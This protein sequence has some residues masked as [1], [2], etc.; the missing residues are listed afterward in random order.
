MPLEHAGRERLDGGAVADVADLDLAADLVGEGAEQVLAARD[1][2][3][4]PAAGCERA[5]GRLADARRCSRDDGD[6][7]HGPQPNQI[8]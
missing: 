7:L 4:V 3:A 1:E 6:P 5:R 8:A 2:D